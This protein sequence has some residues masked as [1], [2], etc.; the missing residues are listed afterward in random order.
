MTT[1]SYLEACRG[2]AFFDVKKAERVDVEPQVVAPRLTVV[3]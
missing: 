1:A 3:G 2:S